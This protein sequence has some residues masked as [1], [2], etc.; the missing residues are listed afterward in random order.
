MVRASALAIASVFALL[1][2]T[3]PARADVTVAVGH[4][5]F[6]PSQVKIKQGESVIFHNVQE[7]PG[8]HTVVADDGSWKSPPLALDEKFTKRFEQS[9]TVKIHLEQHPQATGAIVVE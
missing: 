1:V 4:S 9:G 8:G 2:A 3:V 5:S 6:D 7:M